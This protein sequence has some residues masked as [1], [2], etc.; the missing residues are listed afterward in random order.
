MYV[1]YIFSYLNSTWNPFIVYGI[2]FGNYNYNKH[3][4]EMT[5]IEG[6]FVHKLGTGPLLH[7]FRQEWP[8]LHSEC[9]LAHLYG[10]VPLSLD[11]VHEG[12]DDRVQLCRETVQ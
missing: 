4:T 2:T 6:C 8:C 5:Y 1:H 7:F 10:R 11:G 9:M 12:A 3:Y